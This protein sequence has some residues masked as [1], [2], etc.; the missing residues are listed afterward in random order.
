MIIL[1]MTIHIFGAVVWVGGMFFAYVC[2]RPSVP[3]IEPP[4]ERLKLW[5]RVFTRFFNWVWIAIVCQLI[6]GYWMI[7]AEYGGHGEIGLHIHLMEGTGWLM[8]AIF[9][10]LYFRVWPKFRQAVSAGN[11]PE[12]V[13]KLAII[14]KF[15]A[16]NLTIGLVTLVLGTTGRYWG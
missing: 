4:P 10:F 8:I 7:L 12:G 16:T 15:V 13:E 3:G 6:S 9:L 5:S 1:A 14:R 2:L 11:M